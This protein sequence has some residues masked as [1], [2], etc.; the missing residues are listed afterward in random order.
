MIIAHIAAVVFGTA[1]VMSILI[2]ALETVVL[3][4]SGFTRIARFVFAV[5]D[6]IL[7]HPWKNEAREAKLRGLYA[8]IALVSLPMIWMLGVTLGFS[9]IFWG[10][11]TGTAQRSFEVSGSS[12]TTLG[13][14]A[15]VGAA[16]VWLSFVEAIIGLGLVALLISYLPTIY[17]AHHARQKG[18]IVMRPF[19]GTPPSPILL[20]ENVY[21]LGALGNDQFWRMNADWML[22]LDETHSAF[23]A[24]CFF[25]EGAP[26]E[27][28]VASVGAVL[29]ASS[30]LLS[31]SES[32]TL[33]QAAVEA[34]GPLQA[35]AYGVPGLVR[36]GLAA[37]LP[38]DPPVRPADLLLDTRTTVPEISVRRDEFDA[39]LDRLDPYLSV[40]A[41]DRDRCWRRF[42]SLRSSYDRALQGLAGLTFAT[43]APWTTD[44][45]ARVGRPRAF[46][47][48]AV[49][50]EWF[51]P[52]SG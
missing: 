39:A 26:Q 4:M 18:M 22:E 10:I 27:S 1:V 33:E 13:F 52:G 8:P 41:Q 31:T 30:L 5:A 43:P 16:R 19:A 35:L 9:F 17:A 3:P 2:S 51:V 36:I 12:L 32:R 40:P 28:W 42:S 47:H 44:R 46:R 37:G 25:P 24:L 38:L 15:P 48:Y 7:V 21:R 29:D 11:K 23:P 45:P 34:R 6:W 14:A 20:L 50:I 49:N